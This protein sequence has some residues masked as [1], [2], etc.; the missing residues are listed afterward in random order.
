MGNSVVGA[1]YLIIGLI[2]AASHG[3]F[4]DLTTLGNIISALLAI[5]LWPLVL[6]GVHLQIA[7]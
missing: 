2:I 1:L 4:A 3:Y 5:L 6:V 7:I